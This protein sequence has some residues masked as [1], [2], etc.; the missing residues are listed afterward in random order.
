MLLAGAS[1]V[2]A[3]TSG[4]VSVIINKERSV[5]VFVAILIGLFILLF[6]LGEMMFPH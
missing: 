5:L 6:I 4:L 1:G 2:L 3:F